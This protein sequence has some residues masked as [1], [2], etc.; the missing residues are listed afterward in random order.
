MKVMITGGMGAMGSAAAHRL[1][2]MGHTPVIFDM[3][4][5]Y[6]LLA[7]I[8]DKVIFQPGSVLDQGQLTSAIKD[9]GITR[10]VHTVALLTRADPKKA[11]DIN[12]NGTVNVLWA[13]RD[14][15]LKRLVYLSSKAAYSQVIGRHAHPAYEP[16]NEDYPTEAPLG[17]Y[18][19]TKRTCEQLGLEFHKTMGVDFIGVRFATTFGPGRLSK[20]PNSPMVVPCRIIETA[21]AGKPFTYL[22]TAATRRTTT[23]TPR[24]W[25]AGWPA[26]SSP[27]T[28]PTAYS[29]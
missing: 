27:K 28:P 24:M 17:I 11:I 21:M 10:M 9:H 8:K 20:N 6:S 15:K 4:E 13:A 19:V 25:A 14:C 3:F 23:S 22:P 2:E 12:I 26:P 29:T 7:D 16:I 5:D 1:V 18:G